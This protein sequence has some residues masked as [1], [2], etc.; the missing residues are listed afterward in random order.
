M[1][2]IFSLKYYKKVKQMQNIDS[3]LIRG[4]IDTIILKTMVDGDMYGLD[5]I[6]EVENKSNGTYELKQP[7]LYSCLKRLET[8]ELI[9][10]YWLDSEIG[11]RRHY[12]KLTEKGQEMIKAKQEEWSKSK[13]IIDNLLGDFDSEQYRLVKKDDYEKI[14]EGKPVVQYVQIKDNDENIS[15]GNL[16]STNETTEIVDDTTSIVQDSN[17][18]DEQTFLDQATPKQSFQSLSDYQSLIESVI[19]DESEQPENNE[20][21]ELI[22]FE[23][24]NG[25]KQE[26]ETQNEQTNLSQVNFNHTNN[27]TQTEIPNKNNNYNSNEFVQQNIFE[28][29]SLPYQNEV[30]SS[31]FEFN[32]KV[33]E[34]SNFNYRDESK[35]TNEAESQND[36]QKE[37]F[38]K[39][40][41]SS[42]INVEEN[43]EK[44]HID[45]ENQKISNSQFHTEKLNDKLLSE[46]DDLSLKN[47]NKFDDS[48]YQVE[49][50]QTT[51]NNEN[52]QKNAK[53]DEKTENLYETRAISDENVFVNYKIEPSKSKEENSDNNTQSES[54][55]SDS[56]Q[57]F[58]TGFS[59]DNDEPEEFFELSYTNFTPTNQNEE[60]KKKLQNLNEYTKT[61][62]EFL[63]NSNTNQNAKDILV[64]KQELEKEG[65]KLKKYNKSATKPEQKNYILTNKLNLIKSLILFLLFTFILSASYIIMRN[66][67]LSEM[68]DFSINIFIYAMIPFAIYFIYYLILYILNPQKKAPAKYSSKFFMFF[69]IIITIQLLLII[70]CVNL[71]LGFYS[72]TQLGYNHLFW[73]VPAIISIAPLF[74]T[75]IHI[76]LFNSKN[77]NV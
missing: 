49:D 5:I 69:S 42:N 25:D 37:E 71:Q 34:L 19:N 59:F 63:Q 36:A 21:Q 14:I 77:F 24:K 70:Y 67:S 44:F 54:I 35:N 58:A 32:S 60:Y 51:E 30:D 53:S 7:T 17:E 13:F 41:Q 6:R 64:L 16:I 33:K 23:N 50:K 4:N 31:I 56:S 12:Y 65:I 18:Q 26:S 52:L 62:D 39:S 1:S 22:Y 28:N 43:T 11:G 45:Q 10:S 15:Q 20:E 9:S 2:V 55:Y 66:T 76:G 38:Q 61:N 8:Q 72:F 73:I 40:S 46:L 57:T 3:D 29:L 68:H 75:I 27:S 48:E 74:N 47:E